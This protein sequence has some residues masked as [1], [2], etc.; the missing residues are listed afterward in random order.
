MG[1][2]V[3]HT[4][5]ATQNGGILTGTN[6]GTSLWQGCRR[7]AAHVPPAG[8]SLSL[9]GWAYR[10]RG[11]AG[12]CCV[13]RWHQAKQ[14][15]S[16]QAACSCGRFPAVPLSAFLLLTEKESSVDRSPRLCF[17]SVFSYR[18]LFPWL[19]SAGLSPACLL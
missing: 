6:P 8:A 16:F 12:P 18:V 7:F 5:A 10:P 13:P 17:D 1:R 11:R 9:A 19:V 2:E 15:S 3:K 14:S 4:P